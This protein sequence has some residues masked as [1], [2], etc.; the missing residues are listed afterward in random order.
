MYQRSCLLVRSRWALLSHCDDSFLP[1]IWCCNE[2][3]HL[4]EEKQSLREVKGEA[5]SVAGSLRRH[6]PF[7][8]E[9]RLHAATATTL[10]T[11]ACCSA[12]PPADSACPASPP[13]SS[14]GLFHLH[15]CSL[16]ESSCSSKWS[17]WSGLKTAPGQLSS[18]PHMPQLQSINNAFFSLNKFH[19]PKLILIHQPLSHWP[20]LSKAWDGH[21]L[22]GPQTAGICIGLSE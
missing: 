1:T 13:P 17:P 11:P 5:G 16:L 18:P 4:P 21:W 19:I 7:A 12:A 6:Y 14:L 8:F 20:S 3:P 9:P 22:F 10:R 15:R 2:Y